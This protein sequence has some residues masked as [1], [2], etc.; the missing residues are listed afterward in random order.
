MIWFDLK[1]AKLFC[2]RKQVAV[3]SGQMLIS[4]IYRV[5]NKWNNLLGLSKIFGNTTVRLAPVSDLQQPYLFILYHLQD[6]Y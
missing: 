4:W 6:V 1:D 3:C 5:C 2:C